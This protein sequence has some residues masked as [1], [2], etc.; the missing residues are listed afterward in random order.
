MPRTTSKYPARRRTRKQV[1]DL[2]MHA[3]RARFPHDTV[4][5]SDGYKD[6]IHLTV[7][8]RTFDDMSEK[9]KQALMWEIVD[10]AGLR[11]EEKLLVSL[12][13]PVSLAE[14]R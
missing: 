3:F 6:N 4:D 1:K 8:S 7:V 5:V 9:Q 2:L 14:I 12:I 10:A 13:Y 11:P